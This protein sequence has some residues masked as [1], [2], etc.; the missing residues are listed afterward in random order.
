MTETIAAISTA[1]GE[2]GI[3]I[4]RMSGKESSNIARKVFYRANDKEIKAS[5]NKRLLYGNIMDNSEVVDEVLIAF[6]D[7]PFTY[8][9]EEMGETGF[10]KWAFGFISSGSSNRY[11]KSK[12]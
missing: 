2:S 4:V 10:L 12:N 1:I 7:A 11:Y 3:G 9:R 8:T 5:D 6:M